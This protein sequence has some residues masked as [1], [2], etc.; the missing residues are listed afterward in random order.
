MVLTRRIQQAWKGL[1]VGVDPTLRRGL[2]FG[3]AAGIEHLPVL[4]AQPLT[5]VVDIGANV[6]QFTL[7]ALGTHPRLRVHAFEPLAGPASIFERLFAG[8]A[9]VTLHRVAIGPQPGSASMHVS[10][11]PD[12]S[13]LL[14]ITALQEETFP[15]T[16][17]R[18]T[19]TVIVRRLDECLKPEDIQPPALLK[20]DVQGYELEALRGCEIYLG[21]FSYIYIEVSFVFL[22]ESQ[23][24]AHD[25]IAF[26]S[27]RGFALRGIYNAHHDHRGRSVQAD[28]W[29][30]ALPRRAGTSA[31]RPNLAE[32]AT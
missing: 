2:R 9:N 8:T 14:P 27:D 3:V 6:G 18:T 22:Y 31:M 1:R 7:A 25:V 10:S 24:L 17:E 26:L 13:S 5:T 16:G 15:G 23:A 19:E 20:I 12:S 21:L 29:F 4:R 28:F 30:D 32:R 11:R